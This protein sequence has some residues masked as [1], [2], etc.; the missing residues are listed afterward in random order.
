VVAFVGVGVF[1]DVFVGVFVGVFMDVFVGVF[2]GVF[3]DVFVGGCMR[4]I[5]VC[6]CVSVDT[7]VLQWRA[8]RP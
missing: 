6:M 3:M 2:V 5:C 8:Q 7:R 1:V 4:R